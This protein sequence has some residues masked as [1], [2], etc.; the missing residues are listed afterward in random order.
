MQAGTF[1]QELEFN[2]GVV[3]WF[4]ATRGFGFVLADNGGPDILLHANVL[5]NFGQGSVVE[6]ARVAMM[7]QR[8]PRGVQAAEVLSIAPP[9]G[10]SP[11][12]LELFEEF[13]ASDIASVPLQ[14]ARVKWF[15]KN[16]GFG[17]ANAF[18]CATDIF[19]HIEVLRASGLAD[20]APGEAVGLRALP[21]A[22]GLIAVEIR[23]WLDTGVADSDTPE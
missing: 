8:S 1:D 9:A 21:G 20:L 22:R 7:V 13:D 18:G 12:T 23:H 3:K 4:D 11:M 14:P 6:G 19:V 5:R 2:A 16:K 17:F 15:D 10:T